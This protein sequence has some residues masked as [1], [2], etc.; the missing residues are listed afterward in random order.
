VSTGRVL[1]ALFA[2]PAALAAQAPAFHP[3]DRVAAVVG[4]R[5]I[6]LSNIEEEMLVMQAQGQPVPTDSAAREAMRRQILNNF[7][8][9]ELLV[10]E[11]QRDTAIQVTDA[12]VQAKVE[13]QVRQIRS[14]MASEAEFQRQLRAAGFGTTEEYRRWVAEQARRSIYREKLLDRARQQGK[15]RPIP[16]SDAEMRE[17]WEAN[18]AGQPRRPPTVSFRQVVIVPQADSAAKAKARALADSLADALRK[19]ADFAT[20]ARRFSEDPATREQGGELGWFRRGAMVPEF[21]Q[22]AFALRPGV[23][24][25]PVE[26]PYGYHIIQVTRVQ[27]AEVLAR[28]V[29]IVPDLTPDRV[30]AARALADSVR[31]ALQRVGIA[32]FDSLARRYNAPGEERAAEDIPVSTLPPEYQRALE[33][34]DS[35]GILPVIAVDDTTARPRSVVLMVTRRQ[36]EG[37]YRYEDLKDRIRDALGGQLAIRRYIAQLRR[38]TYIDIRL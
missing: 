15:L 37:E 14:Q 17:F 26:T 22:A 1:V 25:P 5:P 23:I 8:E 20:V 18:R 21:E 9:E 34:S 32:G 16:P 35:T 11:A 13:E 7:I 6:L 28:H 30:A 3:V 4:T 33:G 10:Q 19:G 31:T 38:L 29:L 27:P 36:P 2:A 12:E 24:S